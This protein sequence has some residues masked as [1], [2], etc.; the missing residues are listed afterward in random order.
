MDTTPINLTDDD[1]YWEKQRKKS[2]KRATAVIY[3]TLTS[4]KRVKE[5]ALKKSK[6]D[7]EFTRQEL[8]EIENTLKEGEIEP[9]EEE[10]LEKQKRVK[11]N[12][13]KQYEDMIAEL[14]KD[15]Q[16][17]SRELEE[18]GEKLDQADKEDEQ[19]AQKRKKKSQT[20]RV[21][22]SF[23]KY[24]KI[25]NQIVTHLRKKEQTESSGNYKNDIFD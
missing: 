3:K 4:R 19:P 5:N 14:E 7:L 17:L 25:A 8:A 1:E 10:I 2:Q 20:R 21:E 15:I 11:E 13:I 9:E 23:E 18:E 6:A 22:I 16:K 24:K 12:L